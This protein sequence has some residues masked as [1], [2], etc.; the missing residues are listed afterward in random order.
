M[1]KIFLMLG[2]LGLLMPPARGQQL[3]WGVRWGV[4]YTKG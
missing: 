3:N 2:L 4:N 1:N